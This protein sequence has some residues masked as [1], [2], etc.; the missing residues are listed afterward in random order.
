MCAKTFRLGFHVTVE[1]NQNKLGKI[2]APN[3]GS[4]PPKLGLGSSFDFGVMNIFAWP[5]SKMYTNGK[6]RYHY[7]CV[8]KIF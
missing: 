2:I 4:L 7:T 6:G 1:R 3:S 5:H 8:H